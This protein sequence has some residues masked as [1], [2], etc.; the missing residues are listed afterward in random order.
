[1]RIY[2]FK[3]VDRFK[4]DGNICNAQCCGANWTIYIDHAAYKKIHWIKNQSVRNKILSSITKT[5][6]GKNYCIK[7]DKNGKCP[8]V[9]KDNLCYIQRNLGAD[10]LSTTCQI[11]PR[12]AVVLGGVSAAFTEYD[13]S[14]SCGGSI[15]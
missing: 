6:D 10:A 9:C 15:I 11:Y 2:Q 3:Y 4:C 5:A 7:L 14:S 12:K 1:M 13:L 8:L